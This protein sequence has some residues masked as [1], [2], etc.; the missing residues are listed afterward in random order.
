MTRE[1]AFAAAW[2][3]VFFKHGRFIKDDAVGLYTKLFPRRARR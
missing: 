1:Q 2:K 3:I